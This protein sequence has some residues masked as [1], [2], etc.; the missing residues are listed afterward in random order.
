MFFGS[1]NH[2]KSQNRRW[3]SHLSV[4]IFPTSSS[5]RLTTRVT[6][7]WLFNIPKFHPY[8]DLVMNKIILGIGI[9]QFDMRISKERTVAAS[10]TLILPTA[11][12]DQQLHRLHP[13]FIYFYVSQHNSARIWTVL[14]ENYCRASYNCEEHNTA[15][16]SDEPP[17]HRS[18]F[19]A[20][21]DSRPTL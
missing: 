10:Y 9:G 16:R 17:I 1:N 2:N 14:Y 13:H 18:A 4:D 12:T 7:F 8:V 3:Y 19:L 20:F 6:E 11:T 15:C 5:A 21:H